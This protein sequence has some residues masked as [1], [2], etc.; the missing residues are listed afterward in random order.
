MQ[1]TVKWQEPHLVPAL[2]GDLP[3]PAPSEHEE[4]TGLRR[5]PACGSS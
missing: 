1:P 5:R 4:H 2:R 3:A